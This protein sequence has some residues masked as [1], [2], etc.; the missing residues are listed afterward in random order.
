MWRNFRYETDAEAAWRERRERERAAEES[1]VSGRRRSTRASNSRRDGAAASSS[2]PVTAVNQ[3]KGP[4]EAMEV[5]AEGNGADGEI[6]DKKIVDPAQDA[7]ADN[8]SESDSSDIVIPPR[9][10][11]RRRYSPAH[12]NGEDEDENEDT[13]VV[14]RRKRLSSSGMNMPEYGR[15]EEDAMDL[16]QINR[17]DNTSAKD[18]SEVNV[19]LNTR[20]RKAPRSAEAGFQENRSAS[21]QIAR[22]PSNASSFQALTRVTNVNDNASSQYRLT[23]NARIAAHKAYTS[24]VEF[25]IDVKLAADAPAKPSRRLTSVSG[26]DQPRSGY[27]TATLVDI[28]P[29]ASRWK[30]E[31]LHPGPNIRPL[32]HHT[33]SEPTHSGLDELQLTLQN[34]Y[35]KAGE[36]RPEFSDHLDDLLPRISLAGP[37]NNQLLYIPEFFLHQPFRGTGLAQGV[38]QNILS[39][40]TTL[41]S[42]SVLFPGGTMILSPAAFRTTMEEVKGKGATDEDYLETERK[43]VRS[44]E[45]S[46]FEVWW[47]GDEERGGRAMTIMG[48]RI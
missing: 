27:L 35:T 42:P 6:S 20:K 24:C 33:A 29:E 4:V 43:L 39:W 19:V 23:L 10:R 44:Y 21:R 31:L 28:T 38:L 2:A 34:I 11:Q 37:S 12:E 1:A 45:K 26:E 9:K 41:G 3:P 7:E 22:H 48:R 8:D 13:I 18:D 17:T 25:F 40:I 5:D 30:A 14:G 15:G 36:V 16:D 47:K 32:D 46:G